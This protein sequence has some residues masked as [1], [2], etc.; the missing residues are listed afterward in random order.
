MK[1]WNK[2]K[3]VMKRIVGGRIIRCS[4]CG[5]K[6]RDPDS[7]KNGCGPVCGKL[8]I[9]SHQVPFEF[10]NKNKEKEKEGFNN[11]QSKIN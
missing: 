4:K 3:A 10:T 2:L 7:V 8:I 1:L 11:G 9:I 6:L 5:R